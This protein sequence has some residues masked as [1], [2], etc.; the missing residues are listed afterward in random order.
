MVI[1]QLVGYAVFIR[2]HSTQKPD[3]QDN[4]LNLNSNITNGLLDGVRKLSI[5]NVV[6]LSYPNNRFDAHKLEHKTSSAFDHAAITTVA[7]HLSSYDNAGSKTSIGQTGDV[8]V[9]DVTMYNGEPAALLRYYYLQDV[10]DYFFIVE[11]LQ[12]F[13]GVK[14]KTFALDEFAEYFAPIRS[15][16]VLLKL[17]RLYTRDQQATIESGGA[18]NSSMTSRFQRSDQ[19]R[20]WERE[21]YQR[22]VLRQKIASVMAGKKY[23]AIVSDEDEIPRAS[24]VSQLGRNYHALHD[25]AYLQMASLMYNFDWMLQRRVP[26]S[27]AFLVTDV[28]MNN[29]SFAME[30]QRTLEHKYRKYVDVIT[31]SGWHLSYFMSVQQIQSKL[32]SFSHQE[33]NIRK[34]RS[35]DNIR[36]CIRLGK[37]L[38]HDTIP[39]FE[40]YWPQ[41]GYP[42]PCKN[43]TAIPG[44]E[45]F[46]LPSE[47]D[48]KKG[49]A[50]GSYVSFFTDS[51]W[52]YNKIRDT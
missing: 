33:Y 46:R 23:V 6:S 37:H 18:D 38:N 2:V 49:H 42:W 20:P 17:K 15:K 19:R 47:L 39:E 9:I 30:K 50:N 16:L 5:A 48:L 10:V 25:V 12:S 36:R 22:N 13:S 35:I 28:L 7:K 14:K 44:Y 27:K 24:L 32:A 11:S 4:I 21:E 29:M 8:K 3:K 1:W 34:F 52:V 45:L 40:P 41:F 31:D 51:N 43:C 26:W